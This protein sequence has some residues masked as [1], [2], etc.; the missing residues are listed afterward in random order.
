MRPSCIFIACL[1][2]VAFCSVD[3]SDFS[4]NPDKCCF[5]FSTI[6]IPV[7]QVQ[8][9][10]TAHFQCQKNGIIFVTEQKEICADPTERWVQ[11]LMNLVDAR[12]VK[13]TEASSNGSP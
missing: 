10:H 5:S 1:V 2:L 12:L 3:G 9:Y 11:R 13:D 8:S 4:Q 6:K 7:K